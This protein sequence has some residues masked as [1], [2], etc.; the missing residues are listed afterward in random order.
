MRAFQDKVT[1]LWKW[2]TRGEAKYSTKAECQ[3]AGLDLLCD[4]L[5]EIRDKVN[6]TAIN[7]GK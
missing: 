5:R 6:K 3:R 2:G 7:H 4:K 1:G